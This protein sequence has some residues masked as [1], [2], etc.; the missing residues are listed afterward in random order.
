MDSQRIALETEE[1]GADIL[2]SLRGQR[3]QI[4][5]ARDTVRLAW[6]TCACSFLGLSNRIAAAAATGGYV[7]RPRERHTQEDDQTV[8]PL[9]SSA[10]FS[11]ISYS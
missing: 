1:Q 4:Q 10:S 8:R 5:N 2:R 6:L 11:T 3:E 9:P 7:H